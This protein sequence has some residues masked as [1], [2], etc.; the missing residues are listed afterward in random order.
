MEL[1]KCEEELR[2]LKIQN[3]ENIAKITEMNRLASEKHQQEVID[4][5]NGMIENKNIELLAIKESLDSIFEKVSK[6]IDETEFKEML[7]K[8]ELV[9]LKLKQ[10]QKEA[11][12]LNLNKVKEHAKP[13]EIPKKL[14]EL[15]LTLRQKQEQVQNRIQLEKCVSSLGKDCK[16][17][18]NTL[19][20][21][22]SQ[23][24]IQQFKESI[25]SRRRFSRKK[26]RK[27]NRKS[28][29]K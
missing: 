10:K 11:L 24:A 20:E 2:L 8:V 12:D 14:V 28:K 17:L 22:S 7:R 6:H 9:D 25:E 3:E 23:Q 18:R 16:Q 15:Q 4:K 19:Q 26:N 29:K 27:Y 21:L 5:L 1:E 13:L